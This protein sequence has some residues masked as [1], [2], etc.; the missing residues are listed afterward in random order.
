MM[1]SDWVL[2]ITSL[3]LGATALFVPV[4][5]EF[6]K[7]KVF[8]PKLEIQFELSTP[9]CVRTFWRSSD[10][11]NLNEPVYF[12]RFQ[13]VNNGQSQARL[14]EAVLEELWIYDVSGN[15][16]KFP[17]F[18]PINLRI[19]GGTPFLNINPHRRVYCPIGHISSPSYQE[20]AERGAAI[21]IPGRHGDELRFFL[22]LTQFPFSQPNCLVPG[23]YAI[24][25]SLY[26]ENATRCEIYFQINWS[27]KWQDTEPEMFR[28]LVI[29][30][31][32]RI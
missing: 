30:R 1:I 28:E 17:R 20:K 31:A 16:T 29:Q 27:G 3:F 26:S 18:S 23:K 5:A 12:F 4:L 10:D 14:C 2:V 21:D 25:I 32:N 13:V 19:E 22:E 9:F 7:R 24:K 6:L 11:P 15:P 8:A